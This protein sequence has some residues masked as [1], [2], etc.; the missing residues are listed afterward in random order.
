[1]PDATDRR[2][3]QRA[4]AILARIDPADLDALAAALARLLISA[5]RAEGR[6][7]RPTPPAPIDRPTNRARP[8]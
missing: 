4:D 8:G 1:M 2:A 6:P 7:R 3:E 5:A